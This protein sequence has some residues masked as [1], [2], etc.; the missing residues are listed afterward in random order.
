[1]VDIRC[2]ECGKKTNM[3][4][5]RVSGRKYFVCVKYP[6]CKGRVPVEEDWSEGWGEESPT[7]EAAH[8]SPRQHK[9]LSPAKSAGGTAVRRFGKAKSGSHAVIKRPGRKGRI[10]IDKSKGDDREKPAPRPANDRLS[11]RRIT[12]VEEMPSGGK[13]PPELK[14]QRKSKLA[15][16]RPLYK[17]GPGP[18]PVLSQGP[19]K[20]K[21]APY[22][23]L[24]KR[25]KSWETLPE[26]QGQSEPQ[27]RGETKPAFS[28]PQYRRR[29]KP[30]PVL[31]QE[32]EKPKPAPYRPLYQKVPRWETAPESDESPEP[33]GQRWSKLA[34]YRPLYRR[35]PKPAPVAP[36]EPG[37][38]PPPPYKPL[39]PRAEKRRLSSGKQEPP[40][41]RRHKA[42]K[43][44][45]EEPRPQK[46][47]KPV[48]ERPQ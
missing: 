14:G 2:P 9:E 11:R 27:G 21:P 28:S 19:E 20:P 40:K 13:E 48:Q 41:P 5:S 4:A 30:A 44:A 39:F 16:Y 36:Q 32:T 23:P 26:E 31:P 25:A 10:S 18:G 46:A 7:P 6:K 15:F 17:R 29:P 34:S 8:H 43:A 45:H 12:P 33:K 38:P 1:M 37:G 22:R 3:R 35:G 47:P 42:P 24:F